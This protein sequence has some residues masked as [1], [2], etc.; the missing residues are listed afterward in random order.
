MSVLTPVIEYIDGA[1]RRIYLK[2]GVSDYYPIEDIYHEYR[3]LRR[4]NEDLRRWN[5]FLRAEGNVSKGAG[6]FT[7]R[8]VV[9]I[10][11]TKI[12]PFDESLQVNQLGDMITDNPDVD[13][14]L[15]DISGLTTAK[16][17]FIKPSE[18]ETIQLNSE[19]IVFSSFQGAVWIDETSVYDTKGSAA[20][21]NGN[22]ERPV[23]N[24]PLAVEIAHERGFRIIQVIGN[25]TLDTGDDVEGFK[26]I[27]TSHVNSLLV[28]NDGANCFKTAFESFD[29][30]GVLDG[31]SEINDCVV[32]DI[33]YFNGHI[34]DSA[35]RG[36]ITLAGDKDATMTNCHMLNILNNPVIDCGGSGQ[37]M[38]MTNW[39]GRLI[40]KNAAATNQIG[41]GCAAGDII[42]DESC[43]DGI[44]AIS[45][46]GEVEDN[47]AQACYVI[48]KIVDGTELSNLQRIIEYLRPH[49]TGAGDVWYWDPIKGS[50]D[51]HGDSADRAFKTFAMAH[52]A[53]T[54]ANHDTIIIVPG[55]DNGIT[56]ITETIN[57][58]KDY[59]FLRGPGRDVIFEHTDVPI[60]IQ[61]SARGT[62]FSGFRISNS[63][64]DSVAIYSQG[65]FTLCEN[66]WIENTANGLLMTTHH[67]IIHSVK[68]N[69]P[70]GYA[71]KLEGDITSG[72]IYDCTA[73]DA[74]ETAI[75]INTTVTTGGIKMRDTIVI[76]SSGYGVSLSSTTRK[77]ISE[78][79]NTIKYNTLGSFDDQGE[80]NVTQAIIAS[81]GDVNIIS[82]NGG[83]VD[84]VDDF[85]A[86]LSTI[87][88]DVWDCDTRTLTETLGLTAEQEAKL[89]QILIN[90]DTQATSIK[91]TTVAM[92]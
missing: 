17:I 42:I 55:D 56:T 71:I 30:E 37:N 88:F 61:T 90:I 18:S 41:I 89:D 3:N 34:H 8:Y 47:S 86:D 15:Y 9:L 29:I 23:N 70:S 7:P 38:V 66:L 24:I 19:S 79:S 76:G 48:N 40:I 54:N 49:H 20:E 58:T 63:T 85:K 69:R 31:N 52:S 92:S 77:F 26:L 2:Q 11:G 81:G 78:T 87:P 16:P 35:L 25:L 39:S 84:S 53:V 45:G 28:I 50:D 36:T 6:A 60:S 74:G 27:G 68:I 22:T 75:Q 14:L 83:A 21:P 65:Q 4:T 82:V 13:P 64:P 73:G 12:V 59:L 5:P 33:N 46:T 57:I 44:I 72:E 10:D 62:E 51:H 91:N 32:G 80:D 1:T 67:P 43:L